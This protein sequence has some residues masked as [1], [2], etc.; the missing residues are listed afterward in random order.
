MTDSERAHL[1]AMAARARR[2]AVEDA[3]AKSDQK[4]AINDGGEGRVDLVALDDALHALAEVD[5]RKSKVVELRY[6]GGLTAEET[7]EVLDISVAAVKSEWSWAKM[8]LRRKLRG[9]PQT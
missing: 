1:L 3:R 6:F 8:W 2:A 4:R 5:E 7:A 9:V